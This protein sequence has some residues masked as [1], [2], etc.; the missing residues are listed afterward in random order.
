MCCV[1]EWVEVVIF[2]SSMV[3]YRKVKLRLVVCVIVLIVVGLV[4]MLV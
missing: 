2:S 3:M 1:S 4:R